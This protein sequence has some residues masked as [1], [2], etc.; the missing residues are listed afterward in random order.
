MLTLRQRLNEIARKL[1]KAGKTPPPWFSDLYEGLPPSVKATPKIKP[2][3]PEDPEYRSFALPRSG[4][5]EGLGELEQIPTWGGLSGT[6]KV[7]SDEWRKAEELRAKMGDVERIGQYGHNPAYEAQQNENMRILG[8]KGLTVSDFITGKQKQSATLKKIINSPAGTVIH[9]PQTD[10]FLVAGIGTDI[11]SAGR[12]ATDQ[13]VRW[14]GADPN[15]QTP[16]FSVP[17]S[18]SGGY[19]G[20]AEEREATVPHKRRPQLEAEPPQTFAGETKHVPFTPETLGEWYHKG[21]GVIESQGTPWVGT[22]NGFI[23]VVRKI[24]KVFPRKDELP[25]QPGVLRFGSGGTDYDW[26]IRRGLL[27]GKP[28][29]Q[30]IARAEEDTPPL[31]DPPT[32][33]S[34]E[35]YAAIPEQQGLTPGPGFDTTTELYKKQAGDEDPK[36]EWVSQALPV[37]QPEKVTPKPVAVQPPGMTQVLTSTVGEQPQQIV[38]QAG[39][40]LLKQQGKL[41]SETQQQNLVNRVQNIGMAL[42]DNITAPAAAAPAAPVQTPRTPGPAASLPT[43]SKFEFQHPSKQPF[44]NL[45]NLAKSNPAMSEFAFNQAKNM[46]GQFDQQ[47]LIPAGSTFSD[48]VLR[49]GVPIKTF[50]NWA[51]GQPE[52]HQAGPALTGR[53]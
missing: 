1:N 46:W 51:M 44:Y 12:N 24:P 21:S 7:F 8:D 20:G 18:P 3:P 39:M 14:L 29:E 42:R 31:L 5:P 11:G 35:Y 52:Y 6:A 40:E 15:D 48:H 22:K 50:T 4:P 43:I 47:G 10:S 38:Q 49:Q 34:S 30:R 33:S 26:P 17:P 53:I 9:D 25:T 27:P 37:P 13:F 2:V 28:Y 16:Q 45:L 19:L 23:M 41:A 36:R 32:G